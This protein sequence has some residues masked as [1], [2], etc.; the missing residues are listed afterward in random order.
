MCSRSVQGGLKRVRQ[1]TETFFLLSYVQLRSTKRTMGKGGVFGELNRSAA[2]LSYSQLF[3]AVFVLETI[4]G[5]DALLAF[6]EV[7]FC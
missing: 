2:A 5:F 7:V 6:E 1:Y 3:H 4:T